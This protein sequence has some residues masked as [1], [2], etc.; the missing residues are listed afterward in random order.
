M[1]SKNKQLIIFVAHI[2]DVELSCL[3]YMFQNH[4]LYEKIIIFIASKWDKKNKPW[5]ENLQTIR[6]R[7]K[8]TEIEYVNLGYEQRKLMNHM[9]DLKDSFYKRIHFDKDK[10][11]D[12]LSHSIEDCHTDHVSV[13]YIAKGIFKYVDRFVLVYSPSVINL[14]PNYWVSL[15]DEDYLLK[16]N[17]CD[18]YNINNEQSYTSLGYYLQSEDHYNIGRAY[19]LENYVH[20]EIVVKV[21]IHQPEHFPY[22]GFFQK[23][24]SADLFV[25]LDN[26]N[27]RKN[28]FQNRNK[29]IS[30][31][32][33]EEWITVPVEKGASSK[34]I[35]D[36]M[37]SKDP[38]W[39]KKLVTKIKQNLGFDATEIYKFDKLIDINMASI[40]WAMDK[41]KIDTR[42]VFASD[43]SVDG[44]KSELLAN[45]V[46]KVGGKE[47]ISGPSG[48][49]YLD[50]SF[51]ENIDV[52]FFEPNVENYY[53]CLY[54]IITNEEN[55]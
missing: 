2:D 23:M 48:K 34:I 17:M 47:Y 22:M 6:E 32:K 24:S 51:F 3:S 55:K 52:S 18:K 11:Y 7:C 27:F 15:S 28:Y 46:K 43:L 14:N 20:L 31:N 42:I 35:K 21:T 5:S 10:R 13:A 38:K 53:S 4:K 25:V 12:L 29:I 39:R 49:D 9:D 40:K 30:T 16:K 19:Q 45:I 33:K 36:V 41:M 26:V 1:S 44:S 37:A 50:L 54:N 8:G